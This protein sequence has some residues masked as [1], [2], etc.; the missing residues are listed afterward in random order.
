MAVNFLQDIEGKTIY[1]QRRDEWEWM[2]D[3]SGRYTAQSAYN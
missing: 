2:A 1:T 3:P